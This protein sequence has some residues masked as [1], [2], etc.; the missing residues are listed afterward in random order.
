M[1]YGQSRKKLDPKKNIYQGALTK[2]GVTIIKLD[3][4]NCNI[5][6]GKYSLGGYTIGQAIFDGSSSLRFLQHLDLSNNKIKDHSIYAF[7]NAW[8]CKTSPCLRSLDL[9]NNLLTDNGAQSLS[10]SF[11]TGNFYYLKHLDVSGNKITQKG[12]KDLVIGLNSGKTKGLSVITLE[13]LSSLS[14]VKS[15]MKKAFSYYSKEIKKYLDNQQIT[16]KEVSKAAL[17]VYGTDDWAHCKKFISERSFAVGMGVAAK[18]AHPRIQKLLKLPNPYVKA[19]VVGTI[20]IDAS[21]E[22]MGS[23]DWKDAGHC[24]AKTW[25]SILGKN[26]SALDDSSFDVEFIGN[27]GEEYDF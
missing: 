11:K 19:A 8:F 5:D 13:K 15:F 24:I 18:M 14:G 27:G 10:W 4:S 9:S 21:I 1:L 7:G 26:E 17:K 2:K 12:E 16:N 3:M 22:S 20:V 6:G 25:E 23:V